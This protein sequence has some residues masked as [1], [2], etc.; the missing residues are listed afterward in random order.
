MRC[1]VDY[2]RRPHVVYA[3]EQLQGRIN[4]FDV[5]ILSE[6]VMGYAQAVGAT[7]HMDCIRGENPHHIAETAFKALG[8]ATRDAFPCDRRRSAV[9]QGDTVSPVVGVCDYG[10]GNLHRV[11]R[12]L[13]A[14]GGEPLISHDPA[15]IPRCDGVVPPGVG[16]FAVA[17]LALRETG[18][19]E[20]IRQLAEGGRPVLGIVSAITALREQRGGAWRRR[21]RAAP[22]HRRSPDTR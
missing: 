13:R 22:R 5:E 9:D 16:A 7:I 10:V 20:T 2:G 18:L 14:A 1:V 19:G 3:M 11:E 21:P 4:E 6:F 12:A 17:A 8:L 15:A